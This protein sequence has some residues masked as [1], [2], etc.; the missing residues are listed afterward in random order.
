MVVLK[1]ITLQ[2]LRFDGVYM[3][4]DGKLHYYLRFFERGNVALVGGPENEDHF[5]S[6]PSI[7]TYLTENVQ[8]GWN[9]VHNTPVEQRNDS[10]FFRTMT[11]KGAITYACALRSDTLRVLKAS[12]V[13]GHRALLDYHFAADRP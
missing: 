12:Q 11:M 5:D 3:M 2:G 10:L 1:P 4:V 7:R 13:N 6:T 9:N 8:S